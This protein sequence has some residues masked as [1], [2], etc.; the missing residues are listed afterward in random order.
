[1]RTHFDV[2]FLLLA[3]VVNGGAVFLI[4]LHEG[5]AAGADRVAPGVVGHVGAGL[6]AVAVATV[7]QG[8]AGV[9]HAEAIPV[10][11]AIAG[12]DGPGRDVIERQHRCTCGAGGQQDQQSGN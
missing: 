2:R 12:G 10:Q 11:T 9:G 7:E 5:G 4:N 3:L 1:M 8:A 6:D